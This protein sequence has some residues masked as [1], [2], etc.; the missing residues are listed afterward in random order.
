MFLRM[1]SFLVLIYDVL[2]LIFLVIEAELEAFYRIFIPPRLK[3]V[4]GEIILITGAGHG[5]GRELAI[6]FSMLGATVICWDIRSD[7]NEETAMAADSLGFGVGKAYAYTCD[8]TNRYQ[9]IKVAER[10]KKEVGIVTVMINCC[11]LPSP[12]ILTEHPAPGVRKTLDIGVMS[13]F[14]ILGAF[15][16]SMQEKKHGHIIMLTSVAGLTGI[17]D[18]VP[19]SAAQFAIQGLAESLT[20]ELRNYKP[21]GDVK[22]TLVHIYPFIVDQEMST[23]IQLRIPSYFGTIEPVAAAKKII[24]AMRRDYTEASIPGYLLYADKV[25]PTPKSNP[26]CA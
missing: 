7:S 24:D 3:S 22:V 4:A 16:P 20:E 5:L 9:V 23:N 25:P 26:S 18:L 13:Q 12:R 8:I 2:S 11:N 6:Q 15:L 14:W 17:K 19:L 10:V 21:I 1:Y